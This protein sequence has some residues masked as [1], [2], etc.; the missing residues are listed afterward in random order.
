[1]LATG[2]TGAVLV[3]FTGSTHIDRRGRLQQYGARCGSRRSARAGLHTVL[4]V[5]WNAMRLVSLALDGIVVDAVGIQALFGG[6]G[7]LLVGA[8]RLP[9]TCSEHVVN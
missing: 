1:L 8:A 3:S 4:D 9:H 5:T 7:T 2:A 6:S